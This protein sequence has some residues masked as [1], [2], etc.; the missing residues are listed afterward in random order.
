MYSTRTLQS[1][2][3]KMLFCDLKIQKHWRCTTQVI[4]RLKLLHGLYR[5]NAHAQVLHLDEM[6]LTQL[7]SSQ[8]RALYV[9]TKIINI[10]SLN[11]PKEQFHL[12]KFNVHKDVQSGWSRA[13]PECITCTRLFIYFVFSAFTYMV[14]YSDQVGV[15]KVATMIFVELWMHT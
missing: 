11:N 8:G 12:T 1:T 6:W 3:K 10:I 9:N 13:P 2:V 15:W 14:T 4:N 5:M 7:I